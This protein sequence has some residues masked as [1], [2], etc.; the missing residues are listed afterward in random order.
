MHHC[1]EEERMSLTPEKGKLIEVGISKP[2]AMIASP[3]P[4]PAPPAG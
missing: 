3:P 1:W 2:G 4:I